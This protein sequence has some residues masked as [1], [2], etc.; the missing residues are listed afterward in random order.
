MNKTKM[1]KYKDRI[2]VLFTINLAELG[3]QNCHENLTKNNSFAI[4]LG[5]THLYIRYYK[6]EVRH[7]KHFI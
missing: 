1:L 2:H 7:L 3:E 4:K 5:N 6:M